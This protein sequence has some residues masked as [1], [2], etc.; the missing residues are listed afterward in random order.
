M[1]STSGD[2]G[3]YDECAPQVPVVS[4]VMNEEEVRLRESV[5]AFYRKHN[6]DR[7]K[8]I[9]GVMNSIKTHG[10]EAF[11]KWL[12]DKYGE[13]LSVWAPQAPP[14]A[15][16]QKVEPMPFWMEVLLCCIILIGCAIA[17]IF[18]IRWSRWFFGIADTLFIQMLSRVEC[19][20]DPACT[21]I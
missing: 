20:M 19:M 3:W 9:D 16:K 18:L 8:A 6:P 2:V 15:A 4:G 21:F 17:T 5:K 13:T 7:L 10:K 11:H 1:T 14:P 12:M